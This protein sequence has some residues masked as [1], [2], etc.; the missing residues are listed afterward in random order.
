MACADSVAE[1]YQVRVPNNLGSD[2]PYLSAV[3]NGCDIISLQSEPEVVRDNPVCKENDQTALWSPALSGS[4][5][6]DRP[7][8]TSAPGRCS[9]ACNIHGIESS[10]VADE[11]TITEAM[12]LN[13]PIPLTDPTTFSVLDFPRRLPAFIPDKYRQP[14]TFSAASMIMDRRLRL[15]GSDPN[16][17]RHMKSFAD[18]LF[19]L[20]SYRNA[21]SFYRQVA[22]AARRCS[23]PSD[24]CNSTLVRLFLCAEKC[25]EKFWASEDLVHF[26]GLCQKSRL[27]V[28]NTNLEM[29]CLARAHYRYHRFRFESVDNGLSIPHS[30]EIQRRIKAAMHCLGNYYNEQERDGLLQKTSIGV[31]SIL[32][33]H[34]DQ[35]TWALAEVRRNFK[36]MVAASLYTLDHYWPNTDTPKRFSDFNYDP[37]QANQIWYKCL[38]VRHFLYTWTEY[39]IRRITMSGLDLFAVQPQELLWALHEFCWPKFGSFTPTVIHKDLLSV[40]LHYLERA[41]ELWNEQRIQAF[42]RQIFDVAADAAKLDEQVVSMEDAVQVTMEAEI[43]EHL[44]KA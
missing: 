8:L 15:E 12:I 37:S 2:L 33:K 32:L 7:A 41:L 40:T 31:M 10:R 1:I 4:G 25:H 6:L 11:T 39:S 36:I 28:T 9:A 23:Y 17:W 38:R 18:F 35:P 29:V 19:A 27:S 42:L 21:L 16:F 20:G 14:S 30:I 43:L 44:W 24:H 22:T 26:M 3:T 13:G 34:D 5:G